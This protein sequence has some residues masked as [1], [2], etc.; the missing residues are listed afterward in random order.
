MDHLLVFHQSHSNQFLR[1]ESHI[2]ACRD[3]RK[4]FCLGTPYL[5]QETLGFCETHLPF[6]ITFPQA[7][8]RITFHQSFVD[9]SVTFSSEMYSS[10]ASRPPNPAINPTWPSSFRN[11]SGTGRWSSSGRHR[12]G[13]RRSRRIGVKIS[14]SHGNVTPDL[15]LVRLVAPTKLQGF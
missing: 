1:F 12:R 9:F 13:H 5:L 3:R 2:V 11:A 10:P 6:R 15:S 14:L 7:V 8:K 4:T